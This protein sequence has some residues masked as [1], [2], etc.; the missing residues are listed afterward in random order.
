MY[1][2]SPAVCGSILALN[3]GGGMSIGINVILDSV[4]PIVFFP[5]ALETNVS[6]VLN[7]VS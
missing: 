3:N 1:A 5:A 6:P 2:S 4:G 7:S